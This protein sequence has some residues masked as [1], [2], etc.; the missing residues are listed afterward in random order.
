MDAFEIRC[1]KCQARFQV[2]QAHIGKR[3]RCTR[4]REVFVAHQQQPKTTSELEHVETYGFA[5]ESTHVTNVDFASTLEDWWPTG[6]GTR[7]PY[8]WRAAFKASRECAL[9][10]R[11]KSALK[12]LHPLY[13][14]AIKE[15]ILD[16]HTL[17]RPLAFCLSR[18]SKKQLKAFRQTETKPGNA[19]RKLLN[20]VVDA[21]KWGQAFDAFECPLCQ[22]T[23][24]TLIGLIRIRTTR[25]SVYTCCV[26]VSKQDN[27]IMTGL[28]GIRTKIDLAEYLDGEVTVAENIRKQLPDWFQV[29]QFH[30]NTWYERVI[31]QQESTCYEG[32]LVGIASDN[33]AEALIGILLG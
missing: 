30:D 4:C 14:Q 5:G 21:K 12:I 7:V 18:W 32:S 2:T 11:W 3:V 31:D 28:Q 20:R 8:S 10:Q 16:S 24:Q 17:N 29:I 6:E 19:L 23:R 26:P 25:G 27:E 15:K 9:D 33:A 13:S 22:R 1:E